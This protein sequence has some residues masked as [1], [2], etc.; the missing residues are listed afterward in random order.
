MQKL[1]NPHLDFPTPVKWVVILYMAVFPSAGNEQK[2]SK[3]ATAVRGNLNIPGL[4]IPVRTTDMRSG[5]T[6][7]CMLF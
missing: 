2:V 4:L 3:G 5:E 7:V 1:L 6:N